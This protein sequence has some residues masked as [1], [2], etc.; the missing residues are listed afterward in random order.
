LSKRAWKVFI[1]GYQVCNK[2]LKDRKGR[3]L[4]FDDIAHYQR[5]LAALDQTMDL[6]SAID[7]DIED[8]G[9]WPLR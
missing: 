4:S 9:G 2:W 6:M 1:G 7:V 3:E 8:N 5:I